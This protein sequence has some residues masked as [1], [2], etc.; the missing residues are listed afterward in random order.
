[1]GVPS[2][3]P[4]PAV[5]RPRTPIPTSPHMTPDVAA[6]AP[7]PR[8]RTRHYHHAPRRA[9]RRCPPSSCRASHH[10]PPALVPLARQEHR[11]PNDPGHDNIDEA[12]A[13]AWF[14]RGSVSWSPAA[15][16]LLKRR[17]FSM[18]KSKVDNTHLGLRERIKAHRCST[19]AHIVSISLAGLHAR[20][21]Q[22]CQI[23]QVL[24]SFDHM[25]FSP[26]TN[27]N[28]REQGAYLA[29]P[30]GSSSLIRAV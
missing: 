12:H 5:T 15:T 19:A 20:C 14:Q 9:C 2:R 3:G 8:L 16:R 22:H 4:P 17:L 1:M 6:P 26:I 24:N 11:A 29:K 21:A 25:I 27:T 28:R 13:L 23:C 30:N 7:A 18:A 10:R